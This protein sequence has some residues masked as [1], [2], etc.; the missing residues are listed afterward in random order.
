M[1]WDRCRRPDSRPSPRGCAG[2]AP[3]GPATGYGVLVDDAVDAVEVVLQGHEV[4]DGPEVVAEMQVAGGLNARKDPF[5]VV[6]RKEG[7]DRVAATHAGVPVE[8]G[9]IAGMSGVVKNSA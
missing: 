6:L 9:V 8:R 4:A 3:P 2:V 1:T 5:H 7:R